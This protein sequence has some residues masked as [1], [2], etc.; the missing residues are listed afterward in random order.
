MRRKINVF[1]ALHEDD[2]EPE[3]NEDPEFPTW[4]DMN[5]QLSN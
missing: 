2:G 5:D 3:S 4:N 1:L